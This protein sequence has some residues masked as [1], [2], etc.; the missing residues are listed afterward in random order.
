MHWRGIPAIVNYRPL[1]LLERVPTITYLHLLKIIP[2][3][4]KR[5]IGPVYHMVA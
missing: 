2:R 3:K 5:K 1:L 4:K